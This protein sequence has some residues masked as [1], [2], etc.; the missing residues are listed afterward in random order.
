[1]KIG[2]YIAVV[3]L[4]L[5]A[6]VAGAQQDITGTWQGKLVTAPGS[7]L[8]VQFIIERGADGAYAAKVNSPDTGGVSNTPADDVSYQN[9][10][11]EIEVSALGGS[12]AGAL[13]DGALDGQWVQEDGS[14]PLRLTPYSKPVLSEEDIAS[15]LGAWTGKITIPQG[16][17]TIV[18]RFEHNEAGEFVAFLD[19][20]DQGANGLKVE[21]V[22]LSDGALSLQVPQVRGEYKG[23]LAG[24]EIVGQW[25]QLGNAMPLTVARGTYE[26]PVHALDLAAD[27]RA[28]L[29]GA[30]NGQLGPLALIFRFE[31]S[32]KDEFLGYIDSPNQ[33]ATGIPITAASITDGKLSLTVQAV[34][35]QYV[36]QLTDGKLDGN[37]TQLGQT[38][39]LVMTKQ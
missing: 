37:W 31:T 28:Q 21:K 14:F 17:L 1:M 36:A 16:A 35:G 3:L 34:G 26:A 13:K 38:N 33:G 27:V 18:F 6:G 20:P 5:V 24:D 2:R 10:E 19:S 4:G 15:L 23:Q 22:E 30:W 11:F 39:P 12:F 8:T 7:E 9:G 29:A 25:S 32:E